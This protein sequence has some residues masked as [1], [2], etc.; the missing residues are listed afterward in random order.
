[1]AG[2]GVRRSVAAAPLWAGLRLV[3][4]DTETIQ[5]P[6][7]PHRLVSLGVVT[8]REARITGTWSTLVNAGFPVDDRT[9]EVH[10]LTDDVLADAPGFGSVADT[11]LTHLEPRDGET[12][13]LVAHQAGF[14]IGVLRRELAAVGR[15]LPDLPVL[16]TM[17]R[18]PA[19]LDVR[20]EGRSL[21]KL[22][23][24]L[25]EAPNPAPHDAVQDALAT[26]RAVLALLGRAADAGHHQLEA[27]L[28]EVGAPT[29]ATVKEAG[30]GSRR[31]AAAAPALPDS[32]VA[33][34]AQ[35]LGPRA[36]RRALT[37]WRAAVAECANLR[38]GYLADRVAAVDRPTDE[39]LDV[40]TD[41][42][43]EVTAAG[44]IAGAAT[45]VG[46]MLPRLAALRP[47]KR[48][49]KTAPPMRFDTDWGARLDAL[50]RCSSR[51]RCPACRRD[52]PCPLD[53]WRWHLARAALS[54]LTE[55]TAKGFLRTNG[56]GAGTGVYD[57]WTRT[58][59]QALADE[60]VWF[61][62]EFWRDNG[63]PARAT[64]LA[65]YAWRAG[66]RHP[67]IA[68]AHAAAV[69]APGRAPDLAAAEAVC[70]TALATRSNC[71]AP[72]WRVLAT[73]ADLIA[74]RQ[75]RLA[76]LA[77][78]V[79]DANGNPV[80]RRR[81]HPATPKRRRPLRFARTG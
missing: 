42:L 68:E 80:P 23:A 27:L 1:V 19:L 57:R 9:A 70:A 75:A 12:V 60:A 72:G 50:G 77:V 74:G 40:L 14:D 55:N 43:D 4:I 47:V 79:L 31:A 44:D 24:A 46:A 37:A 67:R 64:Q 38:C 18:L 66:C 63:Q 65:G 78:T 26:A 51:D 11:L 2:T 25:G 54:D 53:L 61:V 34:H 69:A 35:L 20:P 15:E 29:T 71:T 58:G 28:A 5:P 22:L 13:V 56:A 81:H 41:V 49:Y 36:A 45:L 21:D 32:H 62:Y 8:C 3:V 6:D 30:P 17:G 39:L 52:E 73:R 10:G 76:S 33:G 48:S 16:D 7:Q 59:H